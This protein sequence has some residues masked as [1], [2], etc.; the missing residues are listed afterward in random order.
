MNQTG[1]SIA[2]E[3]LLVRDNY[4]GPVLLLEG[5]TDV[6]FFCRFVENPEMQIISAWDKQNVLDA[7]DI[8]ESENKVLGVLGIVD[9]DFGH[10][11]GSLPASRNIV[12]T[13]VHDVE[14]LIIKTKAFSAVLREFG[15]KN[16]VSNWPTKHGIRRDLMRKSI[17]YRTPPLFICN[18]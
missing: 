15:S 4:N 8:L 14:M 2:N 12:V 10:V 1:D 3:V 7:V 18:R 16:K 13:D 9:A 6:K 5:E 17:D 11:D